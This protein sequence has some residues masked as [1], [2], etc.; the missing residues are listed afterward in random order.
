MAKPIYIRKL[1]KEDLSAIVEVEERSTGVARR[2]YWEK[3]IDMSEGIRPYWT[4]IVAEVDNHV[5]GFVLGRAGEFEFGLPGS[6]AWIETIGV[7]P[8]YRRQGIAAK[9]VE[10]F[11]QSADEHRIHTVFTLVSNSN[12]E[13]E[14][15]F[16][17]VGFEQ[18][19]MLHF[20]KE[21]KI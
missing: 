19:Q 21:V 11:S 4:S 3:R 5:V 18:G 14:Q 20:Q 15:F 12:K 8:A 9:L 10:H 13:M 16:T 7:D 6:V 2:A 17:R 1:R